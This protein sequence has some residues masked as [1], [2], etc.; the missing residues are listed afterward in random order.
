MLV[1]DN[2]DMLGEILLRLACPTRLVRAALVYRHWLRVASYPAF[3]CQFRDLHPPRLLGFYVE[4]AFMP[5]GYWFPKFVPMPN[6]PVELAAAVRTANTVFD[7]H[8]EG[9]LS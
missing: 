7:A 4:D 1:L 8:A 5:R 9:R 3:L 2:D 6:L